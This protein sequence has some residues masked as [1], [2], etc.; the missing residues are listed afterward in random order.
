MSKIYLNKIVRILFYSF[1]FVLVLLI[2]MYYYIGKG[3]GNAVVKGTK[4]VHKAKI[5]YKKRNE[6]PIDSITK[7]IDSIIK[8]EKIKK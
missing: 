7:T 3:F 6:N 8:V 5:M 4:E 1:V 2:I